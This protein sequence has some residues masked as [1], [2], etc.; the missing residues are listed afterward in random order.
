M[1][2]RVMIGV[3]LRQETSLLFIPIF[4]QS[5]VFSTCS[6][7]NFDNILYGGFSLYH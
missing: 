1:R 6:S 5:Y 7:R 4:I 2:V 3:I